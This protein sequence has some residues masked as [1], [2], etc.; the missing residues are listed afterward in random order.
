[1]AEL[2]DVVRLGGDL[3]LIG[4]DGKLPAIG[5]GRNSFAALQQQLWQQGV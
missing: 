2:V 1:V 3:H 4:H 5:G